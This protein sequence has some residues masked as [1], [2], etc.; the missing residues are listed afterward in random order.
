MAVFHRQHFM[1]HPTAVIHPQARVHSS[2]AVGPYAVIDAGVEV[3]ADCVIGP[4]VYLTGHTT[5]G[6]GNR[7]H[8]GAVVGDAPQDLNFT[9]A[10]TRLRIGE[11]NVFREH[12]TVHRSSGE[13][14]ETV[15]GANCLFM[16]GSHVGHDVHVGD[17]V[18]LVNNSMI[19]G[20]A[21]VGE[22]AFLSGLVVIGEGVRVG[23]LALAQGGATLTQDLPPFAIARNGVNT[24]CGLNTVG[25]RRAGV[26]ST[27]R[28]ELRQLYHSLFRSGMN[29]HEFMETH[30]PRFTGERSRQLIGF[31]ATSQR[32]VCSDP[33]REAEGDPVEPT[34]D[35]G[36]G[37]AG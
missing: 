17:H 12:V 25:L 3:G 28:L 29:R 22:R 9:G 7:F 14:S 33:S 24:L 15:I 30:A 37:R 2:V 10:P 16:A 6:S 18:I 1:I 11:G 4:H 26:A 5:I 32:G 20:H 21:M 27:E 19:G 23:T 8:A 31:V 34:P 36:A 13:E 35:A